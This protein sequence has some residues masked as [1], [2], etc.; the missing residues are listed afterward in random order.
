MGAGGWEAQR[1]CFGSDPAIIWEI[2]NTEDNHNR[3]HMIY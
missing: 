1:Y 2:W 3:A